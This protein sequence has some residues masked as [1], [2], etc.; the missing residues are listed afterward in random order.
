MRWPWKR[1]EP[2]GQHA[3][4]HETAE[5]AQQQLD[6]ARAQ[7]VH[8]NRTTRAARQMARHVDQFARDFE[9]SLHLRGHA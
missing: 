7:T 3:H 2:N 5:Q 4:A 6:D 8:V 1:H 9:R